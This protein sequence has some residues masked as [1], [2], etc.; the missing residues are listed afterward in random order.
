[1]QV[2]DISFSSARNLQV[3]Q[4][5]SLKLFGTCGT[6]SLNRKSRKINDLRDFDFYMVTESGTNFVIS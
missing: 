4:E 2:K 5:T 3:N 1:M 6:T